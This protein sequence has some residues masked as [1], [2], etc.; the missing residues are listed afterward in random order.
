MH[1]DATHLEPG[2]AARLQVL[3]LFDLRQR[4]DFAVEGE[5][6]RLLCLG[7]RDLHMIYAEN[8]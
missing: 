4:Q 7:Y 8:A 6:L 3:G 2:P 5:A 1:L